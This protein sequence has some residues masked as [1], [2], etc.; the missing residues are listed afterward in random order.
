MCPRIEPS[1]PDFGRGSIRTLN[2]GRLHQVR[3]AVKIEKPFLPCVALIALCGYCIST[4]IQ[5]RRLQDRVIGLERLELGRPSPSGFASEVEAQVDLRQLQGDVARLG[6]R[7]R[8]IGLEQ[9][10]PRARHLSQGE[11]R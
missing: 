11:D 4:T 2:V 8:A 1:G 7:V 3:A 6:R 9:E 10:H 5:V